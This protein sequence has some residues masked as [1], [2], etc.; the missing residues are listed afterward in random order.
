MLLIAPQLLA[1]PIFILTYVLISGRRLAV[2]P[3]GRPAGALLGAVLMVLCGVITPQQAYSDEI[4]SH[5]TLGLL[6]GMMI[7]C[8][9]LEDGG[10]FEWAAALIDRHARSPRGLLVWTALVS[11]GLSA[12]LVNDPVCVLLTPL[13]LKV[14]HRRGLPPLPF[15]LALGCGANVGSALTL[16]GNPQNM[17]IGAFSKIP[18]LGFMATMALPVVAAMGVTVGLLLWLCRAELAA[19]AQ[20]PRV[21]AEEQAPRAMTAGLAGLAVAV[22]GFV[23]NLSM[24]WSALSGAALCILVSRRDSRVVFAKVDFPL[25]V[26]FAALFVVMGALGQV[27]L[28]GAAYDVLHP[29]LQAG[30]ATS[31]WHLTWVS[32]VGS[33]V[34]SNVPLVQALGPHLSTLGESRALFLVL[35]LS[36]TLAGNLTTI[37]S[38]ANVIVL[39]Y[40]LKA[41]IEVGFWRF[42]RYGVPITL[43][44]TTVAVAILQ[45]LLA[46][47]LS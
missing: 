27:G 19:L 2:L 1:L 43:L 31:T 25:L 32:V 46:A 22:V 29:L 30:D 36:S 14:I 33:Q 39:E 42:L 18:F 9:H 35:A 38:V 40:A 10:F 44:S 21:L 5:D 13:L 7:I 20:A 26:F 12:L 45:A 6:L 23:T 3:I 4:L 17:L 24:A 41:G 8:G 28:T 34:F 15:L 47:G 37:G 16:T 11:G